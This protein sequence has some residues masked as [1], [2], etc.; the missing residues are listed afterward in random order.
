MDEKTVNT[1]VAIL[2]GVDEDE[3]IGDGCGMDNCRSRPLLQV[4]VGATS[5]AK[6]DLLVLDDYGLI[7]LNQK[8]RHDLSSNP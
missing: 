1:A 7:P 3:T 4:P 6:A 2:K 5:F 8:Q